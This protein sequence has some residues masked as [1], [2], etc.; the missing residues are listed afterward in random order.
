MLSGEGQG[1]E[2]VSDLPKLP[3][4]R[5]DQVSAVSPFIWITAPPLLHWLVQP[6]RAPPRVKISS[7][8]R[9]FLV[10]A[11]CL[12]IA[13]LANSFCHIAFVL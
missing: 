9:E 5:I 7:I 11:L 8:Q 2:A 10:R 12:N 3:T 13:G 1:T 6:A 4:S